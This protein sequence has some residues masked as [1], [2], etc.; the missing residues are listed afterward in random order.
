M[1][2]QRNIIYL[3]SLICVVS[4]VGLLSPWPTIVNVSS[5]L[6]SGATIGVLTSI[7]QY[8]RIRYEYLTNLLVI[9]KDFYRVF[10]VDEELLNKSI[11]YLREH[12]LEEVHACKGFEDFEEVNNDIIERYNRISKSFN[13]IGATWPYFNY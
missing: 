11:T 6:L 5:G 10:V 7:T 12:S 1:V 4:F 3:L 13:S 8:Y 2:L 9:L